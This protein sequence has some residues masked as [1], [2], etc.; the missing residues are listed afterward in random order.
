M[1]KPSGAAAR[2]LSTA[3]A[4][5]SPASAEC[6]PAA[7]GMHASAAQE[8][9]RNSR[10][11]IATHLMGAGRSGS[12]QRVNPWLDDGRFLVAWG[13]GRS[14]QRGALQVLVNRLQLFAPLDRLVER[15]ALH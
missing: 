11:M 8:M 5:Q 14:M 1:A 13:R 3:P 12:A 2:N 7:S 9:D 4:R 15:R 6:G 10:R